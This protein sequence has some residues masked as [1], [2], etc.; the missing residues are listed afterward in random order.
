MIAE[1]F[2]S[3]GAHLGAPAES[4]YWQVPISDPLPADLG[5]IP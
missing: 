3:D 5:Y 1:F 4:A 2:A